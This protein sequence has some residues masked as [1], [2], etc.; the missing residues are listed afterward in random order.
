MGPLKL[1]VCP[2]CGVDKNILPRNLHFIHSNTICPSPNI[3]KVVAI[4][5]MTFNVRYIECVM[6]KDKNYCCVRYYMLE[7]AFSCVTLAFLDGI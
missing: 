6:F 4:T 2:L 3:I 5:D 1:V 7:V